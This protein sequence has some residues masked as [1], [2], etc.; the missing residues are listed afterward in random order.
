MGE[1]KDCLGALCF[2]IVFWLL[3]LVFG[4]GF[5]VWLC[6]GL[7]CRCWGLL[8][9]ESEVRGQPLLA[10]RGA[11]MGRGGES[12]TGGGKRGWGG[13]GGIVLD[14]GLQYTWQ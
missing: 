10:I 12:L 1:V 13:G 14:L 7:W 3:V 4:D 5:V 9:I 6:Y 8:C 11:K 2:G